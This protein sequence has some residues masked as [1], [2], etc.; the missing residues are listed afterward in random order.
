MKQQTSQQ[1]VPQTYRCQYYY[2]THKIIGPK[3]TLIKKSL[4]IITT[5]KQRNAKYSFNNQT[6]DSLPVL[7]DDRKSCVL[8]AVWKVY[9]VNALES[10]FLVHYAQT[11]LLC[12]NEISC[13]TS[14]D[15][16]FSP[17][18]ITHTQIHKFM[19]S[20]SKTH[21][22]TRVIAFFYSRAYPKNKIFYLKKSARTHTHS[23]R[24]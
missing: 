3:I 15:T 11:L 1:L 19:H 13:L 2:Q 21:I 16:F 5:K 23:C 20:Y 17:H 9:R 4:K 14:S 8:A 7:S 22:Y 6:K 10:N 12:T 18:N 24:G